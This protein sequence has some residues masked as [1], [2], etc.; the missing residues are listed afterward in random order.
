MRPGNRKVAGEMLFEA[1]IP[2][3]PAASNTKLPHTVSRT[4][5]QFNLTAG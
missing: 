3:Q 1:F 4:I 5:F 2:L